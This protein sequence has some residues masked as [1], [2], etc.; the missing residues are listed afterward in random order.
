M[1]DVDCVV[2]EE[3]RL[4]F[5]KMLVLTDPVANSG[6]KQ[7]I[8]EETYKPDEIPSYIDEV[9]LLKAIVKSVGSDVVAR[10][11]LDL[12]IYDGNDLEQTDPYLEDFKDVFPCKTLGL[13]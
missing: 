4:A 9:D 8:D 13:K 3:L 10:R 2:D 7:E 1:S 11:E 12:L 6:L 5:L